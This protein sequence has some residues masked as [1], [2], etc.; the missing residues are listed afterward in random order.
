MYIRGKLRN[1]GLIVT[2]L[3]VFTTV[4]ELYRG[5]RTILVEEIELRLSNSS[6]SQEYQDRS[7]QL[8]NLTLE[9]IL[10]NSISSFLGEIYQINQ[11]NRSSIPESN[12]Y[13]T[14]NKVSFKRL[15]QLFKDN[16]LDTSVRVNSN[17]LAA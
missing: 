2:N 7:E 4:Q 5:I 13:R 14:T 11:I 1:G 15:I 6:L 16:N 12:P 8:S 9:E 17:F 3:E 10:S